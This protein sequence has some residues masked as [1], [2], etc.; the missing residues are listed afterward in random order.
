MSEVPQYSGSDTE[1]GKYG[2]DEK[3]QYQANVTTGYGS[4]ENLD[5]S[6]ILQFE[7]TKELRYVLVSN[8]YEEFDFNTL[9]DVVCTKD[10]FR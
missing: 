10:T 8:Y 4:S 9:S 6:E 7:E 2:G 5:E 3:G 1:K